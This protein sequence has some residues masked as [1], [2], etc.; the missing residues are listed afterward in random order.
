MNLPGT[1]NYWE[2]TEI[3]F[4][5]SE[6]W[7][8]ATLRITGD[9]NTSYH[10]CAVQCTQSPYKSGL[11]PCILLSIIW[12]S[13]QPLVEFSGVMCQHILAGEWKPWRYEISADA[14]PFCCQN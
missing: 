13:P 11:H 14:G 8:I 10:H 6:I 1:H 3:D 12:P 9:Y 5:Q 2:Y 7:M 4:Y